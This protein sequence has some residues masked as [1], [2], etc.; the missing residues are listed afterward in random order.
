MI[1]EAVDRDELQRYV[2][3][4]KQQLDAPELEGAAGRAAAQIG[5]E[6][7]PA[8]KLREALPDD[9]AG[10]ASSGGR[11]PAAPFMARDPVVSLLQSS[12]EHKLREQ[13]VKDIPPPHRDLLARI[14]HFI[15][16]FL[17]PVPFGPEDSGWVTDIA[18]ATLERLAEGNHPFNPK[19]ARHEIGDEARIVIVG[20]WGSGLPRAKE[21]A[22]H[23]AE[24]VAAALAEGRE[25]HVIH[26]GD[27]YYSGT[28]GECERNVLAPGMW[29]VSAE[30]A[31]AGVTS[32]SLNGNHDM[33]GGGYG[34]FE[35]LLKDERFAAQRSADGKPTSFF[36]IVSPSWDL[37]GLD[38]SWNP[39][40]LDEGHFGVLQDP[41]A[42]F[43]ASV[44]A[45]SDRK[46]MLLSHHQLLSVYDRD[47]D[48]VGKTLAQKLGPSL[49]AG[50]VDAW[51]WGH[52]HRCVG[53][54]AAKGVPFSRCIG[55]GGVP[56]LM[57]HAAE[58]PVPPPGEWEEREY[59]EEDGD[60]W[61]R[62]GFAVLDFSGPQIKIRYRNEEGKT[63]R[64][65]SFDP[66]G[67]R[68]LSAPCD[69]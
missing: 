23:M 18:K 37:V 68:S 62:F 63:T 8:Q 67:K 42:E 60:R 30:Q 6:G 54:G 57:N 65:E 31:R 19:P 22:Q 33:Y 4:V 43:V 40:V 29:P 64:T 41:Q 49:D 7:D 35:T 48:Q 44:A 25:A 69:G 11:D 51:I 21:V 47:S 12:L 46:L 17:H 5:G 16:G 15:Q 3:A 13:G 61:A 50:A 45:E 59:W 56:V 14:V 55:N 24:E 1:R 58:D 66:V 32:W 26:L 52:E 34:Y 9:N 20:D 53:Y 27:V 2:E 10:P 28:P 39:D 38:T 36:R